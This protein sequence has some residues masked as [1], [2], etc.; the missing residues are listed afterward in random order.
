[1]SFYY[2]RYLKYKN[3]YINLT[4]KIKSNQLGGNPLDG[5]IYPHWWNISIREA[6][7]LCN[8]IERIDKIDIT[9]HED[10]SPYRYGMFIYMQMAMIIHVDIFLKEDLPY[11]LENGKISES[12]CKDCIEFLNKEISKIPRPT[13]LEVFYAQDLSLPEYLLFNKAV[14][15]G[16]NGDIFDFELLQETKYENYKDF[17]LKE[18]K[19]NFFQNIYLRE[20]NINTRL[21][22]SNGV[23]YIKLYDCFVSNINSVTHLSFPY[24]QY[25][26]YR[27]L[28]FIKSYLAKD[29]LLSVKHGDI[30]L[31]ES[32][33]INVI[34]NSELY[35]IQL[36]NFSEKQIKDYLPR[37]GSILNIST[38]LDL[39][40]KF[41]GKGLIVMDK[42]RTWSDYGI[43]ND[44]TIYA[45]I[46]MKSGIK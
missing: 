29:D 37:F 33:Y 43:R 1:M 12:E 18:G 42:T 14:K 15:D 9:A 36:Y 31:P 41:P 23:E 32:I 7:K 45:N 39:L 20:Y 24:K 19:V 2:E 17:K 44:S 3:K 38:E 6:I 27:I 26:Y 30:N 11:L 25:Q 5:I 21:I 13:C 16:W 34:I 22:P 35:K 4:N 8:E 40:T 28:T 10:D 46:K